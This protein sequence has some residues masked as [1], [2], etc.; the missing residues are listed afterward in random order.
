[1]KTWNCNSKTVSGNEIIKPP[2]YPSGQHNAYD[3]YFS[4]NKYINKITNTN[5][6]LCIMHRK[7]KQDIYR[8]S[9]MHSLWESINFLGG[10]YLWEWLTV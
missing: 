6:K 9:N 5:I 10:Q 7:S 1:M 2:S 3:K 4:P 8:E